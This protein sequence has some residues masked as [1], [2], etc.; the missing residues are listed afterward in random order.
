MADFDVKISGTEVSVTNLKY[1]H[2]WVFPRA[3]APQYVGSPNVY[4]DL[5]SDVGFSRFDADA[6]KVAI[7][8]LQKVAA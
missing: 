8:A 3:L 6:R 1:K 7:E 4:E 2:R 5:R